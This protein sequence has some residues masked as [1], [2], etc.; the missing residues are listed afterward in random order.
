VKAIIALL[1]WFSDKEIDQADKAA[2]ITY[3]AK[4]NIPIPQSYKEAIN[5]LD[6]RRQW[7]AV[8]DFEIG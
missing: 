1:K 5:D 4:H 2:M 6:Y 8:I 7:K 3:A